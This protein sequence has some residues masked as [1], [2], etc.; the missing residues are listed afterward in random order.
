MLSSIGEVNLTFILQLFE[1]VIFNALTFDVV[2]V[3]IDNF[4]DL[5]VFFVTFFGWTNVDG[6]LVKGLSQLLL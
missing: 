6:E 5:H 4:D 1:Y 2:N 3:H